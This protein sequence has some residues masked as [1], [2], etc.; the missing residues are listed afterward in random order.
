MYKHSDPRLW[1]EIALASRFLDKIRVVRRLLDLRNRGLDMDSEP[2]P[3]GQNIEDRHLRIA[4]VLH[5]AWI[6]ALHYRSLS[7]GT[8]DFG[9]EQI[10]KIL[11]LD[12]VF[13]AFEVNDHGFEPWD[14]QQNDDM[15]KFFVPMYAQVL[16]ALQNIGRDLMIERRTPANGVTYTYEQTVAYNIAPERFS[17]L[18]RSVRS[19]L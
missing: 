1:R 10:K 6:R 15:F 17:P 2:Q 9:F 5:R 19:S 12:T 7:F 16:T 18:L 8:R 14:E 11:L 3:D 13:L 4:W